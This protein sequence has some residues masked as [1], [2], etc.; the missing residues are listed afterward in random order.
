MIRRSIGRMP[1]ADDPCFQDDL[2]SKDFILKR[3]PM[4]IFRGSGGSHDPYSRI[5]ARRVAECSGKRLLDGPV[6]TLAI[7]YFVLRGTVADEF[8]GNPVSLGY[9]AAL[10]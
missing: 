6:V 8:Q 7:P 3:H 5:S 1:L 2:V 9:Q 10:L 4:E